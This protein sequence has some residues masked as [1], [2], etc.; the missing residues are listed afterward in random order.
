MFDVIGLPLPQID[1]TTSISLREN[2]LHFYKMSLIFEFATP[3][4]HERNM[5]DMSAE[6]FHKGYSSYDVINGCIL[7]LYLLTH[8][9]FFKKGY[10]I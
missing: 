10:Y 8:L 7:S 5:S 2:T 9:Y 1:S 3:S 6:E 4:V